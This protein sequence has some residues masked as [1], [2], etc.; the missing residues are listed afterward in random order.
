MAVEFGLSFLSVT[1]FFSV[2]ILI[3][4]YIYISI[5]LY[6]FFKT[7][8]V[9]IILHILLLL[10]YSYDV[11]FLLF[12]FKIVLCTHIMC[13]LTETINKHLFASWLVLLLNNYLYHIGTYDGG[14]ISWNIQ[15]IQLCIYVY[16]SAFF[17]HIILISQMHPQLRHPQMTFQ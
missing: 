3:M 7:A 9:V 14:N 10:W 8:V 11:T 4:T 12:N 13:R 1:S 16:V 6:I 5:I 15:Y 2:I 17:L